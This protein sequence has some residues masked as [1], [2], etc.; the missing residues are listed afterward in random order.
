M[1]KIKELLKKYS[2]LKGVAYFIIIL[3]VSH[4]LWKFS[5]IE[6][7]DLRGLPQIFLW[8]SYDL[9]FIFNN[10][11]EFLT[12]QVQ[13]LIQDVLNMDVVMLKNSVY[14][15]EISSLVKIVWS[16][17]GLKQIFV[18]FC[19]IAFYPGSAKHKF[20]FIPLGI[21]LIWILNVIRISTL[22]VLFESFPNHFDLFHELSKYVF[23]F[24]IFMFW[25]FWEEKIRK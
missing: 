8:R 22:I 17:S 18:F 20:W 15:K 23:Y 10:A 9:S 7:K 3:L 25:V 1:E 5:F 13:W 2:Y 11:V 19:I 6:G 21:L 14:V 16:C 4:Y 24:I 12:S